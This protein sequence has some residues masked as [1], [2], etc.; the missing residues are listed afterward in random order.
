MDSDRD[1]IA[2][3]ASCAL[4]V[5]F[6][7]RADEPLEFALAKELDRDRGGDWD[8]DP[9]PLR[10]NLRD[11]RPKLVISAALLSSSAGLRDLVLNAIGFPPGLARANVAS[12]LSADEE[13]SAGMGTAAVGVRDFLSLRILG[14]AVM[15]LS[16]QARAEVASRL[17]AEEEDGAG[18]GAAVGVGVLRSLRTL[19]EAVI[20]RPVLDAR[21]AVTAGEAGGGGSVAF[22]L[23]SALIM[24]L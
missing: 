7:P 8:R 2:A 11:D 5:C 23:A 13:D 3:R 1:R 12:R 20:A 22:A 10:E 9:D 17:S 16:A 19:G 6:P 21:F 14:E 15:A 4:G 18:R 24:M